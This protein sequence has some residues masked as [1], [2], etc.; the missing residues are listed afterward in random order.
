MLWIGVGDVDENEG[1]I[2][3]TVP[4]A[5]GGTGARRRSWRG[6]SSPWPRPSQ[7]LGGD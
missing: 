5:E 2:S 3:V 7:M 1:G 6:I 4:L